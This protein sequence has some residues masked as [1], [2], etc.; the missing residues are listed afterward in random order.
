MDDVLYFLL[1]KH[2]MLWEEKKKGSITPANDA[3]LEFEER[4][5]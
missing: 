5:V 1:P 2:F 3:V 4:L